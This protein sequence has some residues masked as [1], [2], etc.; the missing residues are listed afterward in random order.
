MASK[1]LVAIVDIDGTLIDSLPRLRRFALARRQLAGGQGVWTQAQVDEFLGLANSDADLPFP[2]ASEGMKR[3]L[4]SGL[5]EPVILTGRTE[6]AREHTRRL[7]ARKLGVP[8]SIPLFM[9]SASD[10]RATEVCKPDLFVTH[11]L[12]RYGG[13]FVF[14]ED[15]ERTLA[16]FAKHGL[17]LKAPECWNVLA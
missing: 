12:P 13:P 1:K 2:G 5:F 14:F 8:L 16:E 7:L 15:E 6:L 10:N 11:V 9:R 3:I 17:A 4:E